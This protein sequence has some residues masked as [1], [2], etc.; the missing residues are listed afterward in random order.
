MIRFAAAMLFFAAP[1]VLHA[2]PLDG[3][4]KKVRDTKTLTLAYRTDARP[5]SFNDAKEQPAGYTVDLCKA[6]ATSLEQQ[7]KVQGIKVNWVAVTSQNRIESVVKK[8]VDMECGATTANLS[9]ME[10]VDF[11]SLIFV[12]G[13]GLLVR[14]DSGIKSVG[15]LG[16]KRVGAIPGTTNEIALRDTLKSRLLSATVVPVKNREE[17]MAALEANKIDA[18]ASDKLLILGIQAAVKDPTRYGLLQDYLSIEP[19]AIVL[20]RGDAPLRLAV[21]RALSQIYRSPTILEAFER[22]FGVLGKPSGLLEAM[23]LFGAIPE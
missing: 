22:W 19:L 13:T 2:Q 1:L 9:R 5:F 16:G 4:L 11:S 14:V 17:A 15:D 21:N 20:P 6:I 18:F 23:Y 7:L 12:D 8:Q 3:V 10:Q